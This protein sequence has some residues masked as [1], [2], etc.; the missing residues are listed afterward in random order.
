MET[1]TRRNLPH[2][3]RPGALYFVTYRLAGTLPS[4]V[5]AALRAERERA[6]NA[7][8]AGSETPDRHRVR[9]H[10]R[11]FASYDAALD[12]A[13]GD[14]WLRDPRV[15][16][17]VRSNLYHHN[18]GKYHLLAYCV[19]P[20]HVHLVLQPIAADA[21]PGEMT[22]D[23]APAEIGD[24]DDGRGPLTTIMHS[25]KSF[26]AHRANALLGREGA[27]WQRESYDH[28][29][30]DE[31]E[32]ERIVLYIQHNSV[33]AGLVERPEDWFWCSCH[34]R[35]LTDGEVTAWLG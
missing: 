22:P 16:A 23:D 15:A 11:W 3:Y 35:Y 4:G 1:F 34:D 7:K 17:V 26:T 13:S 2:W 6:L 28:W 10:K 31:D 12:R 19:M 21:A 25:L 24:R 14:V 32:L 8:P 20:N 33:K 9:A 27:F 30:R 5:L 18:G 29:V